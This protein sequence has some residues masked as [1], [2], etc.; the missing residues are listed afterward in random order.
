MMKILYVLHQFFPLH[1]TG[2]E[3]LTLQIA[4]QIQRMGN[5][6]SVLTYEPNN[7][8]ISGFEKINQNLLKKEY[9][10]ETIP[11]ICLKKSGDD[12]I[13]Y[14]IFDPLIENTIKEIIAQ[15]DLVHFIHPQRLSSVLNVCKKLNIPSVLTLTD[16]W[17]LCPLNL[18]TIDKQ[19]CTGPNEGKK[20]L[21]TCKFN[22]DI[23]T[24]YVDAKYFFENVDAVFTGTNFVQTVFK[25]NNWMRDI[26]LNTFSVD[27]SYINLENKE[28]GLIIGFIGSLVW[29]KGAHTLIEAFKKIPDKKI[30]LKIYGSG[31]E[32]DPYQ[33]QVLQM[34][35][36]DPRIQYCGTFEYSQLPE[37]MNDLSLIVI[38]STYYEIFPLVMQTA[39]AYKIPVIASN[40]GGIPEVIHDGKNGYLFELGNVTHLFKILNKI[41]KEPKILDSLKKNIVAPPRIEE[42]AFSYF[43]KY[44]ELINRKVHNAS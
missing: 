41:S 27:Y 17:L 26:E 35:K 6:V 39:L 43:I 38:P 24:R 10:I 19:L 32:N 40:I 18:L 8:N 9:M 11:V 4:K 5:Y 25:S 44:I 7:V 12:S 33:N 42:E 29:H 23:V 31:A 13:W 36:S 28:K 3:R 14:N 16:N 15:F 30:K 2:T 34:I 21:S 37:I 20:C 22:S 1:H